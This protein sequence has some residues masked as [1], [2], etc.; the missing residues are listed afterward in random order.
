MKESAELFSMKI[1][2]QRQRKEQ[3]EG[4]FNDFAKKLR[5]ERIDKNAIIQYKTEAINHEK[6]KRKKNKSIILIQKLFKGY[7]LRK[8]FKSIL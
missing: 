7:I 2:V 4:D 8:K 3:K 5:M 6:E 1:G